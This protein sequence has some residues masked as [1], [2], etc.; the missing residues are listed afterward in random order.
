M[1]GTSFPGPG[2]KVNDNNLGLLRGANAFSWRKNN[3]FINQP[4][5]KSEMT[6]DLLKQLDQVKL[7]RALKDS[8]LKRRIIVGVI[9]SI[10]ISSIFFALI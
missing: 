9:I 6:L 3:N 1:K 4:A 10:F 7:E 2:Q 8:R 5:V